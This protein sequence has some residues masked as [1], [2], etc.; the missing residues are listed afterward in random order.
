MSQSG[1]EGSLRSGLFE[2]KKLTLSKEL[3]FRKRSQLTQSTFLARYNSSN[4]SLERLDFL[5][6]AQHQFDALLFQT[7][8]N[9][10]LTKVNGNLI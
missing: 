10:F 5:K 4:V 1:V 6:L 9:N 7:E 2:K 8:K 3:E